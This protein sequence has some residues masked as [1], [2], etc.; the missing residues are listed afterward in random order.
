MRLL[1]SLAA[2]VALA[3]FPA[4]ELPLVPPS[5]RAHWADD[6]RS[7]NLDD[8]LSLYAPGAVFL[9]P[10]GPPISTAS[11]LRAL[12]ETVFSTYDSD[13]T[14]D[15]PRHHETGTPHHPN[16][17]VDEGTY[18]ETLRTRATG[19]T[20]ILCGRYTFTYSKAT[21]GANGWRIARME[22]TN[23]PCPATN[24]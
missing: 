10:E 22:W 24:H 4:K 8:I 2:F 16:A 12:Y 18:R 19:T 9:R 17:I 13:I 23:D 6:M 11:D 3:Q 20:Q 21:D 14:L 5:L 1:F 7:K 15:P